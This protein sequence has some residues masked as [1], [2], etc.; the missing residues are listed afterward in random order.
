MNKL[1]ITETE[2]SYGYPHT[3]NPDELMLVSNTS[4]EILADE[5]T[6]ASLQRFY[7]HQ[8]NLTII[9]TLCT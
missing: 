2:P 4:P 1:R 6:T 5:S 7:D 3:P 9:L 8:P